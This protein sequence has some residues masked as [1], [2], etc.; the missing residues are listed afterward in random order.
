[1]SEKD[2]WVLHS[3]SFVQPTAWFLTPYAA[4]K[5]DLFQAGDSLGHELNDFGPKAAEIPAP[6]L[7]NSVLFWNNAIV[8]AQGMC[9]N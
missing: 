2:N 1:M 4:P 9:V 7:W 5:T 6:A 8:R 3:S